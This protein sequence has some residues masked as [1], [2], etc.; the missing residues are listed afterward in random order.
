V[1]RAAFWT[2]IDI[3][4][5]RS[6]DE[7]LHRKAVYLSETDQHSVGDKSLVR[8]GRTYMTKS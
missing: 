1:E 7:S 6:Q 4:I 5:A 8:S 2:S 3:C